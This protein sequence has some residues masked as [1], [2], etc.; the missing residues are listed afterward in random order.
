M[1]IITRAQWGAGPKRGSDVSS[2]LP[3]GEVA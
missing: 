3:W 1:E 2:K